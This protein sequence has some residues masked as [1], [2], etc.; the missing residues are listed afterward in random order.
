MIF[1]DSKTPQPMNESVASAKA[2]A[3][4]PSSTLKRPLKKM[5]TSLVTYMRVFPN[6]SEDQ[7][8][9]DLLLKLKY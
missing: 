7:D 1:D 4:T 2:L 5:L 8:K 3:L 9:E 6:S